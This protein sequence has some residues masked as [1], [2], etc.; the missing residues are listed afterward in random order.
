[1]T[2]ASGSTTASTWP[3]LLPDVQLAIV[4]GTSHG[5]PLEKPGLVNQLLIDFLNRG[6]GPEVPADGRTRALREHHPGYAEP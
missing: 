6:A 5:L 1:M 4:P 3:S 2:T